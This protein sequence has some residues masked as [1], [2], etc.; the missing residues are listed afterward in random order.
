[1][2]DAFIEVPMQ[3]K[4]TNP[5][6]DIYLTY[7]LYKTY[8][9]Y[10]PSVVLHYTIKP[11]LYGTLACA[12]L[13]IPSI[14]TVTGLGTVFLRNN[15]SSWIAKKLYAFCFQFS[16]KIVFQNESDQSTFEQLK[17]SYANQ[18]H[19]IKGSGVDEVYFT[20][21]QSY[22]CQE[23]FVFM[24]PARLLYE[25]G[26]KEFIEAAQ[27]FLKIYPQCVFKIIG[28]FEQSDKHGYTANR[29]SMLNL[30]KQI[31]HLPH[32]QDMKT[33]YE[34][35]DVVVLPSYRE[36]LSKALL[37]AASMECAM[38]ASNVPGCKEIVIDQQTGWLCKPANSK[39]LL[40]KMILAYT[41]PESIRIEYGIQA[42]KN[43][44][45]NFTDSSIFKEYLKLVNSTL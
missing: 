42:R 32:C 1:L 12:L 20:R 13:K 21:R 39:D 25:K 24:M 27:G 4:G 6:Q 41:A 43:V 38:I 9:K 14:N 22:K 10:R 28:A 2:V 5:F 31:E 7:L 15:L 37:E 36:G 19:I 33:A 16:D 29:W 8:K 23:P 44:M 17:L 30:P 11:N 26:I 34:K 35:A 45:E 18:H 40:E 3:N